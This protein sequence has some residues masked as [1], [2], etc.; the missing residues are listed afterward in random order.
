MFVVCRLRGSHFTSLRVEQQKSIEDLDDIIYWMRQVLSVVIGIC[1]G[2]VPVEGATGI[3]TYA[4]LTA[5]TLRIYMTM[6][7]T[8]DDPE[9]F[10][11]VTYLLR[12]GTM[13]G[14]GMFMVRI[15]LSQSL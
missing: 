6:F 3:L 15:S 5:T 7:V 1:F 2:I 12:C 8:L 9:L 11:P 13:P 4:V 10:G 14:F